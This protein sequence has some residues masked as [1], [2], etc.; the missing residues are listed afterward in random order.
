MLSKIEVT[1][2]DNICKALVY[3]YAKND[4]GIM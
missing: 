3:A 2:S 1:D 4:R